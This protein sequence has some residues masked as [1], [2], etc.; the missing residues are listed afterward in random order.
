[1]PARV[2]FGDSRIRPVHFGRGLL[3]PACL[4][5]R[6]HSQVARLVHSALPVSGPPKSVTLQYPQS[7][8]WSS[9]LSLF[10]GRCLICSVDFE[11]LESAINIFDCRNHLGVV[12][13]VEDL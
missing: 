2:A 13:H 7:L 12:L 9:L 11:L 3:P 5:R 10:W 4:P 6:A 8:R 1:M